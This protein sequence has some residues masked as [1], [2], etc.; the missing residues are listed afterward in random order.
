MQP[1][2]KERLRIDFL[3]DIYLQENRSSK[4]FLWCGTEKQVP[5]LRSPER[6]SL[7][8][9]TISKQTFSITVGEDGL[10]LGVT[11]FSVTPG[12]RCGKFLRRIFLLWMGRFR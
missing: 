9:T 1:F 5:R 2:F 7:G 3:S 8:M 10:T 11:T 12:R 4:G 6:P